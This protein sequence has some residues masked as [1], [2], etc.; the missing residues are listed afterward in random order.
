MKCVLKDIQVRGY[1]MV[2]DQLCDYGFQFWPEVEMTFKDFSTL[3]SGGH[4]VWWS[5]TI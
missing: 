4:F 2:Q 5:G 1:V 3:N